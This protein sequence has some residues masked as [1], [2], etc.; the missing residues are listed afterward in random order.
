M[1]SV[2]TQRRLG[3][4]RKFH[5]RYHC[6]KSM[7]GQEALDTVVLSGEAVVQQVA[8]SFLLTHAMAAVLRIAPDPV[9]IV[10]RQ[11]CYLYVGEVKARLFGLSPSQM[12]GRV[13]YDFGLAPNVAADLAARIARI[14]QT[15]QP[16]IDTFPISTVTGLRVF[17]HQLTPLFDA[18]GQVTA[19]LCMARDVTDRSRLNHGLQL[20]LQEM[21]TTFQAERKQAQTALAISEAR[22]Q[23]IFNSNIVGVIHW[24]LDTGIITNA[25]DVFLAMVGYTQDDLAQGRL[26]WQEMTPPEWQER[27]WQGVKEIRTLR[28]GTP[29]EKEYFCKDGSRLPLIIGGA[30]F[31]DSNNEGFSFILDISEQKR[32][33]N[34]LRASEER[35]RSLATERIR[36]IEEIENLN[37]RLKRSIQ[38]THHR[39]KNNLQIISALTELQI[40]ENQEMVPTSAIARIGQHTRS[41]AAVHD[42]LTQEAKGDAHIDSLSTQAALDKLIPLLQATTG[43]RRIPYSVDDF[44]LPVREGASLALLVSELVSNAV[45]HGHGDIELTLRVNGD[46]VRLEVCDDGPGFP[47]GFDWRKAANTGLGLIDSTGRHDLRGTISFANRPQGG[48]KVSVT[49][50]VPVVQ[51]G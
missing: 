38:E 34:A 45:K 7:S 28:N 3:V 16:Y 22:A 14:F 20:H 19:L 35:Y 12:V 10:D 39:V 33:E 9:F 44:R 26:N 41:L 11:G 31:D 4:E 17:E 29:Y 46:I 25:N 48:A 32:T 6:E 42:L 21:E 15:Q 47:P 27:N 5:H 18:Q 36:Y 43:G 24:N 50:P 49:F 30:L 23:R 8:P 2:E 13:V 1:C 40:E 51:P 37:A